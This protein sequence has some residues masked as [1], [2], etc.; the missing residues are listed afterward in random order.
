MNADQAEKSKTIRRV[1]SKDEAVKKARSLLYDATLG[2]SSAHFKKHREDVNADPLM[3]V[4]DGD[5]EYPSGTIA[6]MKYD[7]DDR[8]TIRYRIHAVN[9]RG[10]LRKIE[11]KYRNP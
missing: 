7:N 6:E 11:E 10:I 2:A 8:C 5:P 3:V 9:L 4:I 1:K